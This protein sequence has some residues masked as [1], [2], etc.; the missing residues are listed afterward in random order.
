MKRFQRRAGGNINRHTV[1]G[2]LMGLIKS[3]VHL[4]GGYLEFA[5]TDVWLYSLY[6]RMNSIRR[7][8]IAS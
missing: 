3:N 4:Y 1:Y 8:G 5:A 6:N 7:T 2:V